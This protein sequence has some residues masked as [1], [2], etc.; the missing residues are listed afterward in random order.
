MHEGQ[1]LDSFWVAVFEI[2]SFSLQLKLGVE[3]WNVGEARH[4]LLGTNW[5]LRLGWLWT[6]IVRM[7]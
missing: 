5:V 1:L 6:G 2:V 4:E 3:V 7:K